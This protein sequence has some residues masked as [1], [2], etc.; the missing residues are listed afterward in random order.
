MTTEPPTHLAVGATLPEYRVRARNLGRDS[1]NRIHDD[2]VARRYGFAGGL[3]VGT[4]VYAYLS[5]PLVSAL[6]GAWLERGTARVRFLRPIYEGDELTVTGRVVGRSAA[7]GAGEI[8]LEVRVE[9]PSGETAVA[10]VAGLSW[11]A[12][13]PGPEPGDYPVTALPSQRAP[14]EP[15]ALAALGPLG[16]PSLDLDAGLAGGYA[17]DVADEL[18]LYRGSTAAAH[19]GL[20]LQQANRLLSANVALGPW[21]HASSDVAHLGVAR[22]AERLTTRGRVARLY[23]RK[24]RHYVDLEALIVADPDRPIAHV[25]HTA[26]YRLPE[27]PDVRGAPGPGCSLG[28]GDRLGRA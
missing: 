23:E 7:T 10:G 4:T 13:A 6:G 14:A 21:I 27:P 3:V 19:P 12:E 22:A 2:T 9:V 15:N 28:P 11:G 1:A 16:S 17:T 25:R 24:G 26:I 8:V 18:S 20:L 5:S